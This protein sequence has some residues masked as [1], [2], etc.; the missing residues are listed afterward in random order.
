MV[1][2]AAYPGSGGWGSVGTAGREGGETLKSQF[3]RI[4]E[5]GPKIALVNSWNEWQP[6]EEVS[7]EWS[8]DIEPGTTHGHFYLELLGSEIT[9][10]KSTWRAAP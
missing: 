6:Q 8:N 3:A 5:I 10:F 2:S 1:A 7:A 9:R 4:R